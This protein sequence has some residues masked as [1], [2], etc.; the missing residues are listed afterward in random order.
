ML[1]ISAVSYGLI[2]HCLRSWWLTLLIGEVQSVPSVQAPSL[3]LP[4]FA[5]GTLEL[6]VGLKTL[7]HSPFLDSL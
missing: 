2:F 1:Q 7:F 3:P 4:H 5:V 6:V